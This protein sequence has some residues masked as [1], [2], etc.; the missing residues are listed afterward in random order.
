MMENDI[1]KE[2]S[3]SLLCW[4][5]ILFFIV[6]NELLHQIFNFG[7]DIFSLL[8]AQ[9]LVAVALPVLGHHQ[10]GVQQLQQA[11]LLLLVPEGRDEVHLVLQ[12]LQVVRGGGPFA[13]QAVGAGHQVLPPPLLRH[14]QVQR[15]K[16]LWRDLPQLCRLPVLLDPVY[17]FLLL[18]FP[19]LVVVLV[20]VLVV[21]HEFAH[22]RE[23]D[24]RVH[25]FDVVLR[26]VIGEPGEHV[27]HYLVGRVNRVQ[28]TVFV[29]R[30][31][32]D[33]PVFGECDCISDV[34]NDSKR[35]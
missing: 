23:G 16:L 21:L 26:K 8:L 10:H 28:D 35:V 34:I 15:L 22:E 13:H 3:S 29:F 5:I 31:N 11:V 32:R 7:I 1:M 30:S 25:D 18:V 14:L 9:Q 27:V 24:R 2:T 4:L 20:V 12:R 6:E 33:C 19:L 17:L